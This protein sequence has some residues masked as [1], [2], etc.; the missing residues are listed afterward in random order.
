[1]PPPPEHQIHT[2]S[3]IPI[4][5][6]NG[7]QSQ[8]LSRA[9]GPYGKPNE[10]L[11]GYMQDGGLNK[12]KEGHSPSNGQV[13]PQTTEA[14]TTHSLGSTD[15][16]SVISAPHAVY[17]AEPG[18]KCTYARQQAVGAGVDTQPAYCS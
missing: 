8:D 15:Y 13:L 6:S 10:P 7:R 3:S 4:G 5:L 11:F 17:D 1:M 2:L 9:D 14:S 16:Y 12:P 18:R